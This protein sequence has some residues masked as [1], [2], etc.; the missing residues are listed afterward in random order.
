[1]LCYRRNEE[2]DPAHGDEHGGGEVD[3]EDEGP[4]RPRQLDLEP[5]HAVVTCQQNRVSYPF[6]T[7]LY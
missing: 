2:G 5:V 4:Q 7:L 6:F 3:R 1:M